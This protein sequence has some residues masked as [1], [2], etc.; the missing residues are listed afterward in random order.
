MEYNIEELNN[1][2]LRLKNAYEESIEK[3]KKCENKLKRV[4]KTKER[5]EN[6]LKK[7]ENKGLNK[8]EKQE[9]QEKIN[10]AKTEIEDIKNELE[11]HKSQIET[12]KK[13]IESI[14]EML[15]N[16]P[17]IREQ[18][19]TSIIIRADKQIARHSEEKKRQ[20]EKKVVL[21]AL[22]KEIEKNPKAW[23]LLNRIELCYSDDR[24]NPLKEENKNIE[25]IIKDYKI[26]RKELRNNEKEKLALEEEK[27]KLLI[28]KEKNI[29]RIKEI[30]KELEAKEVIINDLLKKKE[31]ILLNMDI[32]ERE[33]LYRNELKALLND[34]KFNEY[35]DDYENGLVS[36]KKLDKDIRRCE[37]LINRSE[38]KIREYYNI[39]NEILEGQKDDNKTNTVNNPD[40][41]DD[42][43][44]PDRADD[45]DSSSS[46]N[47]PTYIPLSNS[48]FWRGIK[49]IFKKIFVKEDHASSKKTSIK[50]I[51][52][53]FIN[54]EVEEHEADKNNESDLNNNFEPDS[55]PENKDVEEE[56]K[57][58]IK[59]DNI[60]KVMKYDAVKFIYEQKLDT[61]KKNN[62][63]DK[64]K[65][66]DSDDDLTK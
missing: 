12:R 48:R 52:N 62:E 45:S 3:Y 16:D 2:Y 44:E 40:R 30:T 61:M 29:D 46:K 65:D 25:D 28:N 66:K 57:N 51:T 35:I 33:K 43:E 60:N 13:N 17:E 59:V 23:D 4:E 18:I 34:P 26:A 39:K 11:M 14:L 36:R 21:E 55:K 8:K 15:H 53:S 42:S 63:K 31:D 7:A 50:D 56:F 38:N 1:E 37:A 54:P 6:N 58:N 9:I 47:L 27:K 10:K 49:N 22:K 64:D 19:D 24:R 20:E 32:F 41:T 5:E